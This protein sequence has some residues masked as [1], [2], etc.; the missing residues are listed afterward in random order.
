[1]END[2]KKQLGGLT[3][4]IRKPI[5]IPGKRM[6]V[7]KNMILESQKHTLSNSAAARWLGI[8]NA[9]YKK[10]ATEYG[11]YEQHNNKAGFGIHTKGWGAKI[12][13]VEDI[14]YGK[15]KLPPQR[16]SHSTMKKELIKQGYWQDECHNCGYNEI[17]LKTG[18][19]CLAVDFEDGDHKNWLWENIRLL[20]PNCYL[21]FN[22]WFWKS[23]TFCR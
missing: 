10:Y 14:I 6:I 17:N 3:G 19:C 8:N 20:C 12:V 15:R 11:I 22:G 23:K 5:H 2:D 21:S 18:T 13:K 7:T 9:T 16:W 1:M 4:S